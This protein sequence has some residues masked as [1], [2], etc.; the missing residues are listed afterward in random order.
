MSTLSQTVNVADF[1][2]NEDT[3]EMEC[4]PDV[5]DD[6][7]G[8]G[9]EYDEYDEYDYIPPIK[10]SKPTRRR[11]KI[12]NS[13]PTDI[14][15]YFCGEMLTK[16]QVIP[17][18][19]DK[20][21]F[22][23]VKPGNGYGPPKDY[24]CDKCKG[25]FDTDE[26]RKTHVCHNLFELK[27]QADGLFHC[28]ECKTKKC[29]RRYELV[30]HFKTVHSTARNFACDQCD[31]KFKSMQVLKKH[32]KQ[33]HL[34]VVKHVCPHC[35]RGFFE[36][37]AMNAHVEAIHSRLN[38]AGGV[39]ATNES[40]ETVEEFKCPDCPKVCNSSKSLSCHYKVRHLRYQK[41]DDQE[42]CNVCGKRI[43]A[44]WMEEHKAM[45][46]PDP[47]FMASLNTRCHECHKTFYSAMELSVHIGR[48]HSL[49]DVI[50]YRCHLCRQPW[51][52][53]N[54]LRK[55]LAEAHKKQILLCEECP[56]ASK[57]KT[58]MNAHREEKHGE[59]QSG[60]QSHPCGMCGLPVIRLDQHMERK[61]PEY[62]RPCKECRLVLE[63]PEDYSDHMVTVHGIDKDDV[64]PVMPIIRP[65]KKPKESKPCLCPICG[66]SLCSEFIL[67]KHI[68]GMHKGIKEFKCDMCDFSTSYHG[69]LT[70]H[71]EAQHLKSVTYYCDKC[72]FKCHHIDNLNNHVRFVH[73]KVKPFKCEFCAMAYSYSRDLAKHKTRVHGQVPQ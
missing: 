9:G 39:R 53:S 19:K 3:E 23:F 21:G 69:G 56:F 50:T 46:H 17:H 8:D 51:R 43:H 11:R 29:K 1:M 34:K 5:F 68:E 12:D 37:A 65:K 55:H 40:G 7:Y 30:G 63:G 4:K 13:G 26:D 28:P 2:N 73:D 47:A 27:R 33:V 42:D 70:R 45:D 71:R 24:Q 32:V 31:Y 62:W 49:S 6:E 59:Q 18:M 67:Q 38:I 64:K 58:V 14:Q 66:K 57:F 61:H 52:G 25:M 16:G 36:K 20:H 48:E 15:C 72:S 35:G 44:L 54:A 22:G 41:N 10:K 60:S